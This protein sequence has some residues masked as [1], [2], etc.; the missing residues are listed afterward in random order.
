MKRLVIFILIM[1]VFMGC[2]AALKTP[3][4]TVDFALTNE[5]V[6]KIVDIATRI[7][8]GAETTNRSIVIVTDAGQKVL[9]QV[10]G[11]EK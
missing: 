8:R 7:P 11:A 9:L 2:A 10:G 3:Y 5:D 6:L 1:A 4:G